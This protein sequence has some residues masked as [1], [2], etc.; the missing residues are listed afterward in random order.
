MYLVRVTSAFL[1]GLVTGL[2]LIVAIGAQNAFVLRQG[3]RREHVG[4]VVAIC[5]V[6]DIFLIGLGTAGIGVLIEQVPWLINAF[7]WAGVVYLAVFAV[8][9]FRSALKP[10]TLEAAGTGAGSLRGVVLATLAFT[11]LNPHAYL[12]AVLI[13]GNL[14]N[15]H[16]EQRWIFA[17]G[18]FTGS[19]IWF[20]ALGAGARAL[21]HVLNTP[22]T[23]RIVD[24]GVGLVMLFIAVQLALMPAV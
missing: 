16:G 8:M 2:A 15:Q 13:L 7:R 14:A 17:A 1:P 19:V 4:V 9:S 11:W 10:Q 24:V 20:T 5:I 22:L 18:V 21:S 6:S 12:D 23:W 3:I